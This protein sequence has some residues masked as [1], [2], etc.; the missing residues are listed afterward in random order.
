MHS[1]SYME[2]DGWRSL[3]RTLPPAHRHLQQRCQRALQPEGFATTVLS[4]HQG[5]AEIT[6]FPK[7]PGLRLQEWAVGGEGLNVPK[8]PGEVVWTG[9]GEARQSELAVS[10]QDAAWELKLSFRSP[11]RL[12]FSHD[13][14]GG[15]GRF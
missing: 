15:G 10:H 7:E 11:I 9:G 5:S 13:S 12:R 3:R 8:G 4:G 1:V 14:Q 2:T 6:G